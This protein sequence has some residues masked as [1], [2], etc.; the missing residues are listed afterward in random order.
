MQ[1]VFLEGSFD[2]ILERMQTRQ[3][4]F[5]KPEMLKSQFDTLE[6]PQDAITVCVGD[7]IDVIVNSVIQTLEVRE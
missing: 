2:L 1:F 4:H 6:V 3:A 7:S 5:M